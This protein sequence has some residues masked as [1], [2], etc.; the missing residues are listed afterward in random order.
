[1]KILPYHYGGRMEMIFLYI[2]NFYNEEKD[3]RYD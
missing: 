1:M 3:I 2:T